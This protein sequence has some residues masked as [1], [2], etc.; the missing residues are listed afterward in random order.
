MYLETDSAGTREGDSHRQPMKIINEYE[1]KHLEIP[2]KK[3]EP[4]D[5]GIGSSY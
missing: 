5:K 3:I 2:T 4:L 1:A